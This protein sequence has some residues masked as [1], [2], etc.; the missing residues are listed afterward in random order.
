[1][2]DGDIILTVLVEAPPDTENPTAIALD[3]V[4]TTGL[5]LDDAPT[6]LSLDA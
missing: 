2:A 4:E 6:E 3:E 5:A 1:M